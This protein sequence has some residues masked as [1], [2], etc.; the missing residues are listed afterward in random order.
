MKMSRN[1]I[2]Q[3]PKLI[4]DAD[5]ASARFDL[6]RTLWATTA[7]KR[8]IVDHIK[9]IATIFSLLLM[10]MNVNAQTYPKE[11]T[12]AQDGSGNYKTIQEAVDALRAYSPE[13]NTV[14]IKNGIYHEKVVVPAWVTNV[15]FTGESKD[16]TIIVWEDYSGKL[17][18]KDTVNNKKKMTT[19]NSYTVYVHGND[20]TIENLTIKNAAGRVG[21]A[22]ALHVDGDRFIIKNCNLLGN[23]DTLLTANDNS[24]QYYVDCYI[25]GTTDFIFGNATA[26]FQ[27]CVIKSLTNSYVT[28]ASTT[29][30]Q[31]YGYV[32]FNCKLIAADECKQEYLGRPWR[33]YAKVVFINCELGKHIRPEGW[34]NWGKTENE[35]TAYYAEYNNTGEGA[36]TDKRVTWSHVLT[37]KEAKKYTL[38]KILNG[39][40][41]L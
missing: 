38:E 27:D 33:A 15:T 32:F 18:S 17:F 3:V 9:K 29:Q 10:M 20:I 31:Q 25:E 5:F 40:K 24:K 21:Q 4:L 39:W 19:F 7:E 41:P 28:A 30:N 37:K 2:V 22:V 23:Q 1:I 13:H 35:A 14:H 36:A 11:I 12:V 34:H 16:S 6:R 8:T 26:V